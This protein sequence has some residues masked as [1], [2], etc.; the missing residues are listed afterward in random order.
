[1][2]KAGIVVVSRGG[3]SYKK[4]MSYLDED[5]KTDV[6]R[7]DSIKEALDIIYSANAGVLIAD[8]N[9]NRINVHEMKRHPLYNNAGDAKGNLNYLCWYISTHL[10]ERL[11]LS[12]LAA[13]LGVTPNYLCRIFRQ[14]KGITLSRYIERLRLDKAA[15]E[16]IM[17][18]RHVQDIALMFGYRNDSYFCKVFKKAYG[19]TPA[20]YRERIR[21]QISGGKE[22]GE[23]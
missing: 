17:T 20:E 12:E 6:L 13:M 21:R 9:E 14:A 4:I 11:G 5:A 22:S 15:Q 7:V 10:G 18:D 23:T 1:M 3:S 2:D 19:L 16:L 8:M